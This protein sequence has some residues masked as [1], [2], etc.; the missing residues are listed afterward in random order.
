MNTYTN[1]QV[2]DMTREAIF[3]AFALSS[4]S[5]AWNLQNKARTACDEGKSGEIF[6]AK[7]HASAA[8]KTPKNDAPIIPLSD[9]SRLVAQLI[10]LNAGNEFSAL[11]VKA[12]LEACEPKE[13]SLLDDAQY[14]ELKSWAGVRNFAQLREELRVKLE[15]I[16]TLVSQV[17]EILNTCERYGFSDDSLYSELSSLQELNINEAW[18]DSDSD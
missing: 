13:I 9:K 3:T 8:P 2:A 6:V 5:N 18:E 14:C 4:K 11:N 10:C 16:K 15:T 7:K 1:Q 17:K 12:I